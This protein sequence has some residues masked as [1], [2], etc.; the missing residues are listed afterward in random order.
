MRAQPR[1]RRA[2][3]LV[4]SSGIAR[5]RHAVVANSSVSCAAD[6]RQV[7][8]TR[9]VPF[10]AWVARRSAF[11]RLTSCAVVA[12]HVEFVGSTCENLSDDRRAGSLPLCE[13]WQ[14]GQM[15]ATKL[16]IAGWDTH[17]GE[18]RFGRQQGAT[19]H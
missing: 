16:E 15:V 13:G 9:A 14:S 12:A 10:L 17:D 18:R 2:A 7:S 5:R 6:P 1:M 4:L 3:S 19:A 8:P 11:T